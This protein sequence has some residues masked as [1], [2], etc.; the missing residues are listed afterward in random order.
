MGLLDLSFDRFVDR[1]P[2]GVQLEG[3]LGRPKGGPAPLQLDHTPF[4][5]QP[6]GTVVPNL[7]GVQMEGGLRRC[8][9]GLEDGAA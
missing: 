8:E 5:N 4:R 7:G 1:Q 6:R 2:G 9:R 3:G